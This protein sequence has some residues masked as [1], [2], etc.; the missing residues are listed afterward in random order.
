MLIFESERGEASL[1]ARALDSKVE[2]LLLHAGNV[3]VVTGTSKG[4]GAQIAKDLAAPSDLPRVVQNFILNHC[5]P[6]EA[7]KNR[8]KFR[9]FLTLQVIDCPL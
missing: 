6:S 8:C 2:S 1:D 9:G 5:L 4:I 7:A 3:A